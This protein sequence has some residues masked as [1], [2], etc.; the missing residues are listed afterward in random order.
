MAVLTR[1]NIV[2][3]GLVLNLDSLNPQSLPVDPT[4]NLIPN[5]VNFTGS[6]WA[7]SNMLVTTSSMAAPYGNET[8]TLVSTNNAYSAITPVVDVTGSGLYT[9]SFFVKYVTQSIYTIVQEG[10]PYAPATFD[11]QTGTLLSIGGTPGF[12]YTAS[13]SPEPNGYYK[14][15]LTVNI[16]QSS[17][18]LAPRLWSGYYN[19]NS[20]SGSQYYLWG[21]QM[22]KS[23]YPT[24]YVASITASG[25]R[26][27]WTDLSGNNNTATL[28]T[29]SVSSTIPRYD[30]LNQRVL[31]FDGTG[32]YATGTLATSLSGSA[33]T[34]GAW[35]RPITLPSERV[36]FSL[37]STFGTD[38]TIHLRFYS[39]TWFRFGMYTDDLDAFNFDPV[40]GK[41]SYVVCTLD[42]SRLQSIYQ[43]GTLK[44]TRT[45]LG[46][47]NGNSIYN[48]G[49]WNG[50]QP[51][52]A[53]IGPV[54]VY[55]R[56]LSQQEILQNYNATKTRFGLS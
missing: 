32:S 41:W 53:N 54:H 34:I 52:N 26:T 22:E 50:T 39:N 51:I 46:M 12:R 56:A 27:T 19:G 9:T 2:T 28:R 36:Y 35:V 15:S 44:S 14:I 21:A 4:V 20:F 23:A 42:D 31:T 49:W 16:T 38:S 6:G 10:N 13:I 47:F 8:A 1:N 48:I 40:I 37:G 5:S 11:I 29:G 30:Y 24:P 25:Q 33:L 45:A 18:T 55:N 7:R 17:F 3:N 43:N